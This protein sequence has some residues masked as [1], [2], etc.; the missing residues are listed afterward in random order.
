LKGSGLRPETKKSSRA[1][2]LSGGNRALFERE[3]KGRNDICE[4]ALK[5]AVPEQK[6]EKKGHLGLRM[7]KGKKNDTSDPGKER[8]K[9]EHLKTRAAGRR[10]GGPKK[11]KEKATPSS[12]GKRQEIMSVQRALKKK[13]ATYRN[14]REEEC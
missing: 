7:C 6:K 8:W 2:H 1:N 4:G 13:K 11:K 3:G 5:C 14:I 9:G 10:G 12:L